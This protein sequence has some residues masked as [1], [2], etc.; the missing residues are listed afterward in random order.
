MIT[1]TVGTIPYSFDRITQ[2][3][4][5]LLAE[6]VIAEPIFF[7]YGYT[8]I[9]GLKSNA[10]I[11]PVSMLTVD[12]LNKCFKESRLVISHAGQGSTRKLAAQNTSFVIVPRQAKRKEHIDDHQVR[13]SEGVSQLGVTICNDLGSLISA[14]RNPPSPLNRDLFAGA[15]LSDYLVERYPCITVKETLHTTQKS[16]LLA[17]RTK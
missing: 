10:L 6:K 13:F 3:I 8:D 1:V 12:E 15:K 2:W 17:P 9:T 7:Q 4:N 5:S 16:S 14:I 11:T